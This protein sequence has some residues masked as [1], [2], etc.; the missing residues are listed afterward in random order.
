[1][2]RYRAQ[3]VSY[4]SPVCWY[5]P[6]PKAFAPPSCHGLAAGTEKA[7]FEDRILSAAPS[8]LALRQLP[9]LGC[10]MTEMYIAVDQPQLGDIER[11]L[12]L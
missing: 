9:A 11:K 8:R 1:M 10:L 2:Q 4:F 3:L 6:S 7:P 5:K 12:S